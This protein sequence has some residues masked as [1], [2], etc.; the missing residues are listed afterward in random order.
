MRIHT[1]EKPYKCSS[2]DD[3]CNLAGS[4]KQQVESKLKIHTGVKP[5][6]CTDVIIYVVASSNCSIKEAGDHPR[7]TPVIIEDPKSQ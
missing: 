6:K 5:F 1:G 7:L 2:C 3:T 4:L